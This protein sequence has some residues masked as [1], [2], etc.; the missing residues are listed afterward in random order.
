MSTKEAGA[1][2]SS[3]LVSVETSQPVRSEELTDKGLLH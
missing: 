2:S 3:N 1:C